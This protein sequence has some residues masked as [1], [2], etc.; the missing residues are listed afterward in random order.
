MSAEVLAP[1][2]R[3]WLEWAVATKSRWPELVAATKFG[4]LHGVKAN[5]IRQGV[6]AK[7]RR[8]H[9]DGTEHAALRQYP[10]VRSPHSSPSARRT[11][12]RCD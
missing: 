6:G 8:L 4:Q 7:L 1:P 5:A 2:P 11:Q 12:S 3:G 9:T 10:A